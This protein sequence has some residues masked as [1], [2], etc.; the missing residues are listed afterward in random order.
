MLERYMVKPHGQL[1]TGKL[2]PLL[3]FHTRPINLVVY[4][5]PSGTLKVQGDLISGEASRLDAFSGY[6]VRT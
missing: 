1:D 5:G 6:P 3:D 2:H 4:K